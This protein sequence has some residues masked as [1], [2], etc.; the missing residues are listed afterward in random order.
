MPIKIKLQGFDE[1]LKDIE[2]AGGEIEKACSSA[3]KQS[4]YTMQDALKKEMKSAV[5][6]IDKGL[7]DRLP[8]PEIT[9]AGNNYSAKVGFKSTNYTP[10]NLSDYHK[11]IFANYG[12]PNRKKHGKEAP[13]HFVEKAKKAAAPKIKKQQK[14][15]FKKILG[16]LEK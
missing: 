9:A 2:A 7:S 10:K 12:T 13:R 1:F 3:I 5:P 6:P 11:A 8:P 15:V 16:R 4:A 14:E